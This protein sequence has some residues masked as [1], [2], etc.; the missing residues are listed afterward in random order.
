MCNGESL[1]R[2]AIATH[3]KFGKFDEKGKSD[4]TLIMFE[5]PKDIAA[6]P[7]KNIGYLI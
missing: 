1:R 5:N 7:R 2:T 4:C 6:A 3:F